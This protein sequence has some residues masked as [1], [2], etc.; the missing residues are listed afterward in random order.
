MA[1]I[2]FKI[3]LTLVRRCMV[4]LPSE[5]DIS[6]C[7]LKY[8]ILVV[9]RTYIIFTNKYFDAF[10]QTSLKRKHINDKKYEYDVKKDKWQS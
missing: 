6:F 2:I 9:K 10:P 5:N 7:M 3:S 1:N 8:I 4:N